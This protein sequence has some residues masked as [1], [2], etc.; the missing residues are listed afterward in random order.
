MTAKAGRTATAQCRQGAQLM[1]VQVEGFY[2]PVQA[3]Q[4]VA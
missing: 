3:K 4:N 1:T 2:T